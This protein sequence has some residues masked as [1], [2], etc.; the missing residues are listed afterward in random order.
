MWANW[1]YLPSKDKRPRKSVPTDNCEMCEGS[2]DGS[3]K[4][5]KSSER[6]NYASTLFRK[7]VNRANGKHR[8]RSAR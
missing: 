6:I 1:P 2:C 5:A 4:T 3:Q 7:G 8:K